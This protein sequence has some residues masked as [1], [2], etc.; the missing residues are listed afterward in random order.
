MSLSRRQLL[1]GSA[2]LA[3]TYA[4]VPHVGR[5]AAAGQP[6]VL[7]LNA[8]FMHLST[9]LVNHQLDTAV[10]ARIARSATS[11]H[12]NLADMMDAIIA[13]AQ[14]KNA[15]IV[16]DFFPDIPE[17][18]MK[19]LAYWII[20]AWYSGSSSAKKDATLFTYE[21]ALTFQITKDATTIPSYG[22]S[23]PNLWQRVN[24]PLAPIPAF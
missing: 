12:T 2:A 22:F 5:F 6:E 18:P 9:L 15:T 8:R 11:L 21:Q 13:I 23:G 17:G 3:G 7:A 20:S 19:D 16:E 24:A 4:V 14:G 10:G 1:I